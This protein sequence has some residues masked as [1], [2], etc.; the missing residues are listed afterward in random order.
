MV[1]LS[2]LSEVTRSFSFRGWAIICTG[3]ESNSPLKLTATHLYP[4][5]KP[6]APPINGGGIMRGDSLGGT[7][8]YIMTGLLVEVIESE[9]T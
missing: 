6:L 8:Q 7:T 9:V 5:P 4:K 3:P 2:F 1:V